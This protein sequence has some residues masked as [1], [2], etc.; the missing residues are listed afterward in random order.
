M[1]IQCSNRTRYGTRA[2]GRMRRLLHKMRCVNYP[3]EQ[4]PSK[5]HTV[6]PLVTCTYAHT[7]TPCSHTCASTHAHSRPGALHMQNLYHDTT[8]RSG[9]QLAQGQCLRLACCPQDCNEVP[10]RMLHLHPRFAPRTALLPFTGRHAIG[11]MQH[12]QGSLPR[13]TPHHNH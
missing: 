4:P 11:S 2:V 10:M 12:N 13:S 8:E 6:C 5:L 9:K 7:W 3:H 1:G